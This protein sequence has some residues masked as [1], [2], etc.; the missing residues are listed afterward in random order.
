MPGVEVVVAGETHPVGVSGVG[1][2]HRVLL[3]GQPGAQQRRARLA[4]ADLLEDL[5]GQAPVVAH[6]EGA[7]AVQVHRIGLGEHEQRLEHF[8]FAAGAHP[9]VGGHEAGDVAAEAVQPDLA[10]PEGH[11][12]NHRG[13]QG[14]AAVVQRDDVIPM[15][16][17][18]LALVEGHRVDLAL[19]VEL[20]PVL[21]RAGPRV[22]P[23]RMVG[24]PVEH[25]LEAQPVRLRDKGLG[26]GQAAEL[27]IDGRVVAHRV[28]AAERALAVELADRLPG[29]QPQDVDTQLLQPRQVGLHR[30]QRAGG[31][32]LADVD[33]VEDGLAGP[34]KVRHV[35][36][37]DG[38]DGRGRAHSRQCQCNGGGHQG[39]ARRH[40]NYSGKLLGQE[41]RDAVPE[42]DLRGGFTPA[43][44][45]F[46]V[47]LPLDLP[48]AG[49]LERTTH[50][51]AV[52]DGHAPISFSIG[53]QERH[54]DAGRQGDR[55]VCLQLGCV[56]HTVANQLRHAM[57]FPAVAHVAPVRAVEQI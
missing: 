3:L 29:H 39:A 45:L 2:R 52:L 12:V 31:R 26:V 34:R 21:V 37:L 22:V 42:I 14:F 43:V 7:T 51:H 19:G 50:G 4:L 13:T 35:G 38:R 5:V 53:Q 23:G 36:N 46:L 55:G 28:V 44:P 17:T 15:L 24:H 32:I 1:I 48:V 16:L 6:V 57:L 47:D 30:G 41:L 54:L 18:R 11:R 49:G 33:L 8:Q 25:D 27:R 56:L 20:V 40:R 9:E 10:H